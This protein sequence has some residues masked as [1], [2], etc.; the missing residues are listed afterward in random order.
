MSQSRVRDTCFAPWH[1]QGGVSILG[2]PPLAVSSGLSVPRGCQARNTS[3]SSSARYR[4]LS[5]P[6]KNYSQSSSA[7]IICKPIYSVALLRAVQWGQVYREPIFYF[8]DSETLTC[9]YKG[10]ADWKHYC[11]RGCHEGCALHVQCGSCVALAFTCQRWIWQYRS[12]EILNFGEVSMSLHKDL[13][14]LLFKSRF[15]LPRIWL[16]FRGIQ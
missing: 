1:V 12:Q 5:E 11:R 3:A 4:S 10:T 13:L 9:C 15:P 16:P 2:F 8:Q 14:A 6:G 7:C